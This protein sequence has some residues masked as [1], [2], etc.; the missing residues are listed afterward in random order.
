MRALTI[1]FYL[2]LSIG[3]FAQ[4]KDSVRNDT[5]IAF[6]C[7]AIASIYQNPPLCII[8]NKISKH[9][10]DSLDVNSIIKLVV[11]KDK[12]AIKKYG[13]KGKNGVIVITTKTFAINYYQKKFSALSAKYATYLAENHN[14]EEDIGYIV[15]GSPVDGKP[16][17]RIKILYDFSMDK[18]KYFNFMENPFYNGGASRKYITVI[19][20]KK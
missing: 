1:I 5:L 19:T 8:D 10:L 12:E 3:A 11:F 13:S 4:G 9:D 7:H 20:T 17:G 6:Q 2:F 16:E 18:I 14:N 15:N